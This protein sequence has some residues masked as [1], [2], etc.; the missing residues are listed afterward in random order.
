MGDYIQEYESQSWRFKEHLNFQEFCQ[1]EE[2]RPRNHNRSRRGRFFVPN[3][4]GSSTCTTKDWIDQLDSYL[5]LHQVSEKEA[6][7]IAALHL[8]GKA[9]T[10]WFYESS[11]F[12]HANIANYARFSKKLVKSFDVKQLE[13]SKIELAKHKHSK[14][15]HELERSIA[16]TPL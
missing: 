14:P 3:F 16:P 15:L 11:S 9:H 10:W 12:N 4:D 2:T 6:L 8:E 5:H 7:R 13:T 1:L